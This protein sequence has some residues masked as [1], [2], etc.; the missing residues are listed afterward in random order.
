MNSMLRQHHLRLAELKAY[1][2]IFERNKPISP[3]EW[4]AQESLLF[5]AGHLLFCL[6]PVAAPAGLSSFLLKA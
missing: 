3:A 5:E 6:E 1:L 2:R 4:S